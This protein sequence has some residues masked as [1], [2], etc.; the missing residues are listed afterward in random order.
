MQEK[1]LSLILNPWAVFFHKSLTFQVAQP[2]QPLCVTP[3]GILTTTYYRDTQFIDLL[4]V[5]TQNFLHLPEFPVQLHQPRAA[6]VNRNMYMLHVHNHTAQLMFLNMQNPAWWS[7]LASLSDT[8]YLYNIHSIGTKIYVVKVSRMSYSIMIQ[9]KCYD[10]TCDDWSNPS[11]LPDRYVGNPI[12]D[13]LCAAPCDS[14]ILVLYN[15]QKGTCTS[16]LCKYST[17]EDQWTKFRLR[18][19][20]PDPT[21]QSHVACI[22][23]HIVIITNENNLIEVYNMHNMRHKQTLMIPKM[24]KFHFTMIL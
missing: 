3:Y 9:F 20:S 19:A 12:S 6:L 1:E 14:G 8:V 2:Q 17:A 24:T 10:T 5:S 23:G 13:Y 7:L 22:E 15:Y 11:Q 18:Y 21:F 16:I 4:D